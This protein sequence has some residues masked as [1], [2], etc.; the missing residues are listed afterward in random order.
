MN[1]ENE[2]T[3]G[4]GIYT[5][6]DIADILRLPYEQVHRWINVYW[7]G[8]LGQEYKHS[9][10][11]RTDGSQAVSFHTLVE[12][13]L[14]MLFGEA[15]VPPRKV[16][17]A[18]LRLGELY[19][20]PFPFAKGEV[21]ENIRTDEK[22]IYFQLPEGEII[23]LDGSDQLNLDFIRLFFQRLDFDAN[24][25]ANKF[26]PMGKDKTIVVDPNRKFGH[27]LIG[28]RNIY[29]ETLYGHFQAGDPIPY[30]AYVYKIEAQEVVDA[31]EF[32]RAA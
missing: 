13:Y 17:K 14:M 5:P 23:S 3:I 28:D 22:H 8:K 32:C 30:I 10:S 2:P 29:P 19:G 1:F 4:Q 12:F 18:H 9:Y 7:D 20:T 6:R 21:L 11:W 25:L 15:G 26:W 16:M 31:L 27:P 24:D